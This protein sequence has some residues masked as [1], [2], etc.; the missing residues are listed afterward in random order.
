MKRTSV[1]A[2]ASDDL[3]DEQEQERIVSEFESEAAS[4]QRWTKV[5]QIECSSLAS[6]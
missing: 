3:L 4:L 2:S 5:S 1:A 6:S